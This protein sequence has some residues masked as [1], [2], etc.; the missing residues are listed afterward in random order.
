[1][2]DFLPGRSG[3]YAFV[4]FIR[5]QLILLVV[6]IGK[7]K[8]FLTKLFF[9]AGVF[10][11]KAIKAFYPIV[12]CLISWHAEGGFGNLVRTMHPFPDAGEVKESHV[13]SCA[14]FVISEE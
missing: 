2:R 7:R 11:A 4:Q 13:R 1:N 9:D 14:A 5:N 12:Q 10:H 8:R 3:P 6:K